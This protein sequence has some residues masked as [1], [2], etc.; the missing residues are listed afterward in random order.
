MYIKYI[1]MLCA[2]CCPL[3]NFKNVEKTLGGALVFKKLQASA[4]GRLLYGQF[5]SYVQGVALKNQ[6]FKFKL[7]LGNIIITS[8]KCKYKT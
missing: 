2:I 7:S 5:T 3:F 4:P 6:L 8:C 1:V